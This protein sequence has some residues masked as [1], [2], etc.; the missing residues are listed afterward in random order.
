MSRTHL[1]S[2]P[3]LCAGLAML[4]LGLAPQSTAQGPASPL[5][6]PVQRWPRSYRGHYYLLTRRPTTWTAARG[7]ARALGG[8]LVTIDD[9]AEND[10]LVRTFAPSYAGRNAEVLWIGFTDRVVEGTWRWTSGSPVTFTNWGGIEPNDYMNE[11]YALLQT[12]HATSSC[13]S[14]PG[15]WLDIWDSGDGSGGNW[16]N[17]LLSN[18]TGQYGIIEI[19]PVRI[20]L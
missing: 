14:G 1:A 17:G 19:D 12:I 16:P 5:G 7:E 9:S 13:C 3:G 2:S 4:L 15:R 6:T 20:A 10:W 18:G 11:D 8:D